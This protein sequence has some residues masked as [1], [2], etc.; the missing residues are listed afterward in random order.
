MSD[1]RLSDDPADLDL[2]RVVHWIGTD[3]YW[4]KG[5]SAEV[6]ERSFAHSVP[7][8]V[9]AAGGEQVAVA[10]LVSD[11]ATFVWLCDV[12]VDPSHRGRGIGTMLADWAVAWAGSRGIARVL[13]A[14]LDA[15]GVYGK[16]G[17]APL[18]HPERFMEIDTRPP[19]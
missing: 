1:Y 6:I 3:A 5:R 2:G 7:V 9:F 8:G 19:F 17:F 12:Y 10:R 13:L 15:H 18:G 14:T 4:A 11:H 16:A